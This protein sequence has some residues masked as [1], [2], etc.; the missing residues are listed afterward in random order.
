[1]EYSQCFEV[2]K[3]NTE[4]GVS[5]KMRLKK[6]HCCEWIPQR[7]VETLKLSLIMLAGFVFT[8]YTL[9][10]PRLQLAYMKP[11]KKL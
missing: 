8:N 7:K 6:A 9:T 10:D 5:L 3:P 11:K 1:M 2:T 4:S